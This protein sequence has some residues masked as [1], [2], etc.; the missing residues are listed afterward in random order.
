MGKKR[1]TIKN[2]DHPQNQ[3]DACGLKAK[4]AARKLSNVDLDNLLKSHVS[5]PEELKEILSWTR[6]KKIGLIRVCAMSNFVNKWNAANPELSEAKAA[7]D[8]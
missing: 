7:T 2:P 6:G 1:I 4:Q 8:G 5:D 3:M